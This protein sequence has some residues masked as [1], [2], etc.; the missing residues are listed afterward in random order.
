[1]KIELWQGHDSKEKPS[2]TLP[3]HERKGSL[4]EN[5]MIK[6]LVG[7]MNDRDSGIG[8]DIYS[9]GEGKGGERPVSGID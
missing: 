6:P 1:M 9:A 4:S 2:K 5:S 8:V 7:Y 3:L